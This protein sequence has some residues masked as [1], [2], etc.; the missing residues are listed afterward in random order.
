MIADIN[1]KLG[2][3]AAQ[4]IN[5]KYNTNA[6]K[7]MYTDLGNEKDI[8]NLMKATNKKFGGINILV[9]NAALFIFGSV[10]G[11]KGIGSKTFTDR[12][13]TS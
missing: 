2:K 8:K 5:K 1:K 7:F 4:R 10:Y 6:C 3:K 13:V 11:G 12:K 9:N